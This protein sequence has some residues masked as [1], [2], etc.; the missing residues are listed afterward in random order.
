VVISGS[1]GRR[2]RRRDEKKSRRRVEI[3]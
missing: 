2:A 3:Q 1:V